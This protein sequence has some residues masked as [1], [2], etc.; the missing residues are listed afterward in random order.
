MGHA[1]NLLTLCHCGEAY[2]STI[3]DD[4][5]VECAKCAL[6]KVKA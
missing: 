1:L 6:R 4:G 3:N 2:V 5:T